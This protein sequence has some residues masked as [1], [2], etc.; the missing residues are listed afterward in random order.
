M[1]RPS[2]VHRR[3]CNNNILTCF[4]LIYFL[5][6]L[7]LESKIKTTK[8]IQQHG[9]DL[10]TTQQQGILWHPLHTKWLNTKHMKFDQHTTLNCILCNS[11]VL[12]SMRLYTMTPAISNHWLVLSLIKCATTTIPLCKIVDAPSWP[13][14]VMVGYK[15]CVLIYFHSFTKDW[16]NGFLP[17]H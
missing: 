15:F 3:Y 16:F 2:K 1:L 10:H 6:F 9:I 12:D 13:R 4:G 7:M 14:F 11:N 17:N 8:I 5:N